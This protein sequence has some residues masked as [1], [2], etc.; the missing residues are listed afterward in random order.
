MLLFWLLT[1]SFGSI[2][3]NLGLQKQ[4]KNSLPASLLVEKIDEKVKEHEANTV[5]LR[6]RASKKMITKRKLTS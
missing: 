3:D 1:V 4:A 6:L 2:G 5:D